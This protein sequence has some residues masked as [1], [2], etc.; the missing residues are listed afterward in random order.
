MLTREQMDAIKNLKAGETIG[1]FRFRSVR[2]ARFEER[3]SQVREATADERAKVKEV[4]GAA[5]AESRVVPAIWSTERRASDTHVIK[6]SAWQLERFEKNPVV[7]WRHQSWVPR[8]GDAVVEVKDNELRAL[9]AFMPRDLNEMSFTLGEIAATRGYAASVGWNTLA[10]VPAPD[11]IRKRYPWALDITSAELEEGSLVNIGAD[12]D[13]FHDGRAAGIDLDPIARA[14]SQRIDEMVRGGER[15]S[16]EKLW[17]VVANPAR[18]IV[19]D[20]APKTEPTK[21][22]EVR[23][24]T[25]AE[26]LAIGLAKLGG[27]LPAT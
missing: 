17:A 25:D 19:V 1:G 21:T 22:E 26:L 12:E 5:A 15:E 14:L 20:S 3:K 10:A 11:D 18:P 13:A 6:S 23:A 8:I 7:L 2:G 9:V 16:L 27:Q 4:L 24:P